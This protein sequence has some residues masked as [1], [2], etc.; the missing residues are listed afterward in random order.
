M[1][2]GSDHLIRS[3]SIPLHLSLPAFRSPP[4]NLV[5][6]HLDRQEKGSNSSLVQ[7]EYTGRVTGYP[8][9]DRPIDCPPNIAHVG[10]GSHSSVMCPTERGA[11][12]CLHAPFGALGRKTINDTK[13]RKP[14]HPEFR[15]PEFRDT[16]F[17]DTEFRDTEFRDKSF[18]TKLPLIT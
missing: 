2:L 14:S 12:A 10:V 4:D 13:R 11:S 16:E 3:R 6:A 15:D 9:I 18:G 8:E 7:H 5:I 17:R 1:S